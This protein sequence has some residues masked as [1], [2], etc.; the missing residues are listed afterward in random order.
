MEVGEEMRTM[1][2]LRSLALKCPHCK[3]HSQFTEILA[4]TGIR[5]S[6]WKIDNS[7]VHAPYKCTNCTGIIVTKWLVPYQDLHNFQHTKELHMTYFPFIGDW[8]PQIDST[9]ISNDEVRKD[10]LEA[11]ECY[12]NGLY[13]AC[14]MMARRAIQQEMLSNNVQGNNLYEQ[15][16]SIGISERLKSLLHKIKN[17]GN[18]GA[19]PDFFLFDENGDKIEDEKEFAR[20]SL[21]FLDRYFADQYEIDALIESAPKSKH[22]LNSGN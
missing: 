4:E 3:V 14:M 6:L 8:S 9:C 22:E 10:F 16:E 11:S 21:E 13:V 17:F 2:Y 15:I 7:Y 19:H 5:Y 20:L 12:N 1:K 18:H